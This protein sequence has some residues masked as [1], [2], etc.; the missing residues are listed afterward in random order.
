MYSKD[1][2][3][4]LRSNDDLIARAILSDD[5]GAENDVGKWFLMFGDLSCTK[6]DYSYRTQHLLNVY[7]GMK[8]SAI[9]VI[10]NKKDKRQGLRFINQ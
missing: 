8:S 7:R 4:R 10:Q 2:S 6:A 3:E 5:Y 9:K 1:I